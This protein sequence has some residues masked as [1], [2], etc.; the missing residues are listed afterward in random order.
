M[1]SAAIATALEAQHPSPPLHL[2]SPTLPKVFAAL[3]SVMIAIGPVFIPR[4]PRFILADA[5][6]PYWHATRPKHVG[7]PL[8]EYERLNPE[9]GCWDKAE[10][11]LAEIV[12]LLKEREAEGPF[13]LG[14]EVSYADFVWAGFLVFCKNLGEEEVYGEVVRRGGEGGGVHGRLLEGLEP[15]LRRCAE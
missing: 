2:D 7:M 3:R 6:V 14:G 11:G 13:F 8:E 5:S 12:A 15:W 9:A 4:V 1:D 10:E